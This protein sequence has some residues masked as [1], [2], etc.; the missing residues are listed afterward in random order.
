[1]SASIYSDVTDAGRRI[2]RLAR[3]TDHRSSVMISRIVNATL[4]GKQLSRDNDPD[5][6]S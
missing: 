3:S 5:S 4:K 6:I 2:L 1:V